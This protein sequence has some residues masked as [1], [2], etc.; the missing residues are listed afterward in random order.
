MKIYLIVV[1]MVLIVQFSAV[2]AQDR[3]KFLNNNQ[4]AQIDW[5]V[6]YMGYSLT[7]VHLNLTFDQP[8]Y[9]IESAFC[10]DPT[11][12]VC[13]AKNT[14][15]SLCT[16]CDF[17]QC[18]PQHPSCLTEPACQRLLPTA[19]S[20]NASWTTLTLDAFGGAEARSVQVE[21]FVWKWFRVFLSPSSF[22]GC[23]TIEI[24]TRPIEGAVDLYVSRHVSEPN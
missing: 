21:E 5:D 6:F 18:S 15:K 8:V 17:T 11:L 16:H 7:L 4:T 19:C 24:M 10:P 14:D 1:T 20:Q 2:W 23:Q 13:A 3:P 12:A 9:L 22:G